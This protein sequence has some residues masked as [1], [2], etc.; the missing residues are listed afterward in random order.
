MDLFAGSFESMMSFLV[1][2]KLD[3]VEADAYEWH[4]DI[5]SAAEIHLASSGFSLLYALTHSILSELQSTMTGVYF[6][7][8][9]ILRTKAG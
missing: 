5:A 8:C 6:C 1:S 3:L 9:K 4:G 7:F 2:L